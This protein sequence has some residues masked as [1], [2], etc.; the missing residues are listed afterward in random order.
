MK[1]RDSFKVKK[2]QRERENV[3]QF[4]LCVK[5]QTHEDPEFEPLLIL[6]SIIKSVFIL[7]FI[8]VFSQGLVVI[9]PQGKENIY[10]FS[11]FG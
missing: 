9:A 11:I 2:F 7:Q 8:I 6:L 4:I 10:N 1:F 3:S 5:C